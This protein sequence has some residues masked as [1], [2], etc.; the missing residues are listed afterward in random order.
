MATMA[1]KMAESLEVLHQLQKDSERVV[2]SGTKQMSRTHLTRLLNAGYLQ[3]VMKGWYISSKPGTEGDTTVWYT[4]YW[5]FI[6]SYASER[7]GDSW[8]LTAEQSLDIYSGKTTV[9]VQSIIRSPDGKNNLTKL[10]YG[11]SLFDL[12][13]ELPSSIH[14]HELYGLNMYTLEEALVYAS[15]SYFQSSEITAR[16]CLSMVKDISVI[17]RI[18]SDKGASSRAGRLAGAFRNMGNEKAADAILQ[19]M[20]KIGYTVTE[21]DPFNAPLKAPLLPNT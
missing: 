20:K 7:F 18:L 11:T 19:F 12:K 16:I 14:K 8:S 2:L 15:P 3:E 17:V 6:A 5:Y 10:M 9:P 13:A 1:E 4:S 21:E